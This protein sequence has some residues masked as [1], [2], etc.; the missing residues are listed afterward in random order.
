MV[1]NMCGVPSPIRFKWNR[2][3][4]AT[5]NEALTQDAILAKIM[6]T[7][8]KLI[9]CQYLSVPY[10]IATEVASTTENITV[11]GYIYQD[12]EK[13][14]INKTFITTGMPDGTYYINVYND[15]KDNWKFG[16]ND[17]NNDDV[18]LMTDYM[19]DNCTTLY[20][21]DI[22]NGIID[23]NSIMY[24]D[25][26]TGMHN[27]DINAHK[28]LFDTV[29][30]AIQNAVK[31]I[32]TESSTRLEN[33]NALDNKIGAHI[34]NSNNPHTVTKEQVGLGSV[35][36]T[37]PVTTI[38]DTDGNTA[39]STVTISGDNGV[40]VSI[41]SAS[42]QIE[43]HGVTKTIEYPENYFAYLQNGAVGNY[44]LIGYTEETSTEIKY[45]IYMTIYDCRPT[46]GNDSSQ[47]VCALYSVSTLKSSTKPSI[48]TDY[49]VWSGSSPMLLGDNSKVQSLNGISGGIELV[50]GN[51]VSITPASGTRKITISASGG[52]TSTNVKRAVA[53]ANKN[54]YPEVKTRW[55]S[56]NRSISLY[57]KGLTLYA[58]GVASTAFNDSFDNP[59]VLSS[60]TVPNVGDTATFPIICQWNSSTNAPDAAKLIEL[61]ALQSTD[62]VFGYV[63][64]MVNDT[65]NPDM[66]A[67]L[68][69]FGGS[70]ERWYYI[71]CGG[72]NTVPFTTRGSGSEDGSVAYREITENVQLSGKLSPSRPSSILYDIG[73][74]YINISG[75]SYAGTLL[76]TGYFTTTSGAG[77]IA[78]GDTVLT[79]P[80]N[81]EFVGASY[82]P[83]FVVNA[84][85]TLS[86]YGYIACTETNVNQGK[87][88]GSAINDGSKVLIPSGNIKVK[89]R[90]PNA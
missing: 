84:N 86:G 37:V 53:I 69:G 62:Y 67:Y 81:Y 7:L 14:E 11:K 64:M 76:Y 58:D 80:S 50:A 90:V 57:V 61:S 47:P 22:K 27:D 23:S 41:D 25:L 12:Y 31:A 17:P 45:P 77:T 89:Y 75:E 44:K 85:N 63:N 18:F 26:Y 43:V 6:C 29:D 49:Y 78:S 51:N 2:V 21:F 34:A 60:V 73:K 79:L 71:P 36:N 56:V 1:N 24:N 5:L 74:N 28:Q 54:G 35:P 48:R 66:Y 42:K 87:Y 72:I 30:N 65:E 88:S 46:S 10:L 83:V 16:K 20:T 3:L 15:S 9:E 52:G 59:L 33:D 55:N 19:P 4:P 8:N 38:G 13:K 70:N 39:N 32:A 82:L 40:S 68:N